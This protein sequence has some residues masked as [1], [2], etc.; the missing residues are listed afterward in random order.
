MDTSQPPAAARR[1]SMKV[2][3]VGFG[4]MAQK[5]AGRLRSA[6]F[7]TVASDPA[8]HGAEIGG[9]AVIH[10]GHSQTS[11]ASALVSQLT[12]FPGD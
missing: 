9:V 1:A 8:H 12:E 6:G 10:Y 4:A 11:R 3:F 7:A 2:G 5:M